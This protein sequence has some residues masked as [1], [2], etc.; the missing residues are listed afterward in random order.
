MAAYCT[1]LLNDADV[2][3][4]T[5][6]DQVQ[7]WPRRER[8]FPAFSGSKGH[9]NQASSVELK[10][11]GAIPLGVYYIVDRNCG[12]FWRCTLGFFTG[13]TQ[14]FALYRDD[15]WIDDAT[16]V[17]AVRRGEFR[18]HGGT[19][20]KGCITLTSPSDFDSLRDT[21]RQERPLPIPGTP[22][23]LAYGT[24]LVW[25]P[26]DKTSVVVR[27]PPQLKSAPNR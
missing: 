3:T 18:L 17:G 5:L 1:F 4:L 19:L 25:R 12:G 7:G 23:G 14:W 10:D 8:R 13:R 9:F 27:V 6:T 2:S 21:L 16:W 26:G 24:V 20:S 11:E 22:G 15:G